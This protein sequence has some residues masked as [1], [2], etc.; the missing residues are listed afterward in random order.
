[1]WNEKNDKFKLTIISNKYEEGDRCALRL[2]WINKS[3]QPLNVSFDNVT[4]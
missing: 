1:M 2:N 4:S 3:L